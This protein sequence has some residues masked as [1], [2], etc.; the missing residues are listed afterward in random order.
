MVEF[1][2]SRLRKRA[3]SRGIVEVELISRELD[4]LYPR[5]QMIDK[6]GGKLILGIPDGDPESVRVYLAGF[7]AGFDQAATME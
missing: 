3:R 5:V 7:L 1:S 2:M 6:D 4:A